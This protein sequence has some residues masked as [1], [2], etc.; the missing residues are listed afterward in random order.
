MSSDFFLEAHY[1]SG[2]L[3]HRAFSVSGDRPPWAPAPDSV[4]FNDEF[5]LDRGTAAVE[6]RRLEHEERFLTWL[7]VYHRSIDTKLGDRGNH[8]GFGL[9]LN[10][11]TIVDT[12]NA[13]H[14]LDVLSKKLAES[15]DPDALE[16]SARD[17]MS[18]KFVPSYVAP[19]SDF[20]G[21]GGLAFAKGKLARTDYWFLPARSQL[22]DCPA[23]AS[24]VTESLFTGANAEGA[25]RELICVTPLKTAPGDRRDFRSISEDE[26]ALPKLLRAIPTVTSTLA[27]RM[28]CAEEETSR[29]RSEREKL[30]SQ[31]GDLNDMKARIEKFEADPL[32]IV[33]DAIHELEKKIGIS[34]SP[35]SRFEPVRY[36]APTRGK[37]IHGREPIIRQPSSRTPERSGEVEYGYDWIVIGLLCFAFLLVLAIAFLAIRS[38]WL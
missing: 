23:L 2:G 11:L 4:G 30:Q 18:D 38:G 7:G 9:W 15:V 3:R 22:G 37:S 10:G 1:Y 12:R 17:F 29:L 16:K 27:E 5:P 6:L 21:F 19:L 13:M 36:P 26:D 28:R 33:L 14:G 20:S 31:L 25:S 24:H 8:A 35:S 34:P 32:N